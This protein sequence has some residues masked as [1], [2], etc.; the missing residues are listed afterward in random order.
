M[1]NSAS[2]TQVANRLLALYGFLQAAMERI[3]TLREQRRV[4]V[5]QCADRM[6]RQIVSPHSGQRAAS[7]DRARS[8]TSLRQEVWYK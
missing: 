1:Q 3:V 6:C 4:A 5:A 8:I 7:I 2:P